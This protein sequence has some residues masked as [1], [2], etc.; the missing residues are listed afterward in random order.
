MVLDSDS[1]HC[2]SVGCVLDVTGRQ[3]LV[4]FQWCLFSM[5]QCL[6]LDHDKGYHTQ[7]VRIRRGRLRYTSHVRH[8]WPSHA[9]CLIWR[10][11]CLLWYF[12]RYVLTFDTTILEHD[13]RACV[14]AATC[15]EYISPSGC[16]ESRAAEFDQ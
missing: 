10:V 16:F 3:L 5:G 8:S 1:R 4:F 6:V 7:G 15:L 9:N 14:L 11:K 12:P 13:V 2:S